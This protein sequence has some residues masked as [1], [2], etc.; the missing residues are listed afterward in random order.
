MYTDHFLDKINLVFY[1]L[2]IFSL[3]LFPLL[4]HFM[5][6]SKVKMLAIRVPVHKMLVRIANRE[7]PDQTASSEAV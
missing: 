1:I 5:H 3:C 7:D 4:C 2:I 6:R